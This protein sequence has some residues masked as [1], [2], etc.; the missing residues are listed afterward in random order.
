[1]RILPI[2][3]VALVAL[4]GCSTED[5]DAVARASAKS[6]VNSVVESR[7]PNVPLAPSV[8]CV[9]D[10]ASANEILSLAADGVTGPDEGTAELVIQIAT[11]RDTLLCLATQGIPA[12]L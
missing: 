10:N 8:N 4:A 5:A 1:M 9:I 3:F 7:F 6:A 11:R 12:F 2:A